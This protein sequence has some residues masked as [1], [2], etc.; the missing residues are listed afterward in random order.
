MPKLAW[1]ILW[2]AASTGFARAAEPNGTLERAANVRAG[3]DRHFP[4][5]TWLLAGTRVTIVGC[6]ESWRWCDV[7][8]G[9]DRGWVYAR[10]LTVTVGGRAE[11]IA[12]AGPGSGLPV[13]PFELGTYWNEHY[14]GR[15]FV[16]R[17]AYWERRWQTRPAQAP[18]TPPRN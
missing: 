5:A 12:R 11:T 8:A 15:P 9:R 10:Y 18:W 7:I 1:L 16:A 6:V 17:Q 13:I 4:A 3:P 2:F 14:A